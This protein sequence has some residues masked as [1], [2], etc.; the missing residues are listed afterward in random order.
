MSEL[1]NVF[2]SID[3][4]RDEIIELQA[5]LTSRIAIGPGNGG[6]G[7]YEIRAYAPFA[8]LRFAVI[9][10]AGKAVLSGLFGE[11]VFQP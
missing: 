9:R 7:E 4:Y 10:I 3:E 8:E 6:K 5:G 11:R 2:K 1:K